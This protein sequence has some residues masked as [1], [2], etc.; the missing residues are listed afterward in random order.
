MSKSLNVLIK[1]KFHK[2]PRKNFLSDKSKTGGDIDILDSNHKIRK[3]FLKNQEFQKSI[4]L[5]RHHRTGSRYDLINEKGDLVSLD[6]LNGAEKNPLLYKCSKILNRKIG[7]NEI[8]IEIKHL[9]IIIKNLIKHVYWRLKI[10]FKQKPL[11][12]E[13]FGVDGAGKTYLTKKINS[14][15]KKISIVKIGH[16]WRLKNNFNSKITIPYKKKN[17]SFLLSYFKEFYISINFVLLLFRIYIFSKRKGI[18]IFERSTYDVVIDPSRYRLSHKIFLVKFLHNFFFKN[19]K[20]IYLDTTYN[21]AKKRKGEISK[22]KY[23]FLKKRLDNLFQKK[24][25]NSIKLF[26]KLL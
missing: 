15:L 2:I 25:V 18:Y 16:L 5:I 17:Y 12:I 7:S 13:I 9:L 23:F 20:K 1:K 4:I 21:L 11:I 6:F 14:K 19:S 24:F 22:K 3:Y 26:S 8:N 10:F